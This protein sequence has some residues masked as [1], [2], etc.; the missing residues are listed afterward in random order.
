MKRKPIASAI[1]AAL[2]LLSLSLLSGVAAASESFSISS[3]ASGQNVSIALTPNAELDGQSGNLYVAY[4]DPNTGALYFS[5]GSTWQVYSAGSEPA[6]H[7][8]GTLGRT[9]LSLV[10]LNNPTSFRNF[11]LYAGYGT[12]F[13]DMLARSSYGV[14]FVVP[15]STG[16]SRTLD[17]VE[18]GNTAAPGTDQERASAYSRSTTTVRYRDGSVE[19]RSLAYRNLYHN[20]DEFNGVK[21]GAVYNKNGSVMSD[22]AG[23]VYVS[24]TPDANSLLR[25]ITGTPASVL[26]GNPLYLVTQ[27]EYQWQD[28]VGN[29]LYGKLPMTMK[30][31]NVDQN[32]ATGA[33][34]VT[35]LRNI[36]FSGVNGL[37]IPCA[38]S[39][40]PWNT[41]LGS[42]EYEPDARCQVEPTANSTCS[43]DATMSLAAMTSYG[44]TAPKVYDY[45]LTPEVT[46][47]A[48]GTSTVVKHRVLGRLSREKAEVMPDNKTVY[49]GDDG[50]YNV[51]TMFLADT[52]SDLSAGTLYAAK[53]TQTSSANGGAGTLTW[54]KLGHA[55]DAEL[56]TLAST[57]NFSDIFETAP[58]VE[59]KDSS[60]KVTGYE[61]APA[62][63]TQIIAGHNSGK[64]ENLKLKTGME[65][66]AAFLETRRY[67]A[68]L[69]ATTEWEKY[70]GVTVN[71]KDKKAYHAM[72]RM[73]SGM[74]TSTKDP[75]DHIKLTRNSAGAV[76]EMPMTSAQVDST[77]GA[78][79]SDWVGTSMKAIVVGEDITKDSAGNI[80]HVDKIC[81]P[82]NLAFSEKM[83]VL[84]IGE[85]SSSGHV[86]NFLW[87]YHVDTGVLA[88][89]LSLPAGAESTGLQVHDSLNGFAYIMSNY[90]HAGDFSSNIDSALKSRLTPLID[91]RKAGV[92][93]LG[94]LPKL[95]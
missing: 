22:T 9:A 93:Y 70:E 83:R 44:L 3:S 14:A 66:A 45:G 59:V 80:C 23:N 28:T 76:Y 62:G 78:I 65:K 15:Q 24:E 47:A 58:V 38:G 19:T 95:D 86:N 8:R 10:G 82:D 85:D 68:Y 55:T 30:L 31:A 91:T 79:A 71:V 16:L 75:V 67:A 20:T 61:A 49:Q 63:Y 41:H 54:V 5:D 92:G 43:S 89:V 40:S 53:F 52:A 34:T 51:V 4:S 81:S 72:T 56:A 29:D 46:V 12:S 87:A 26:G 57:L 94:N 42:E 7:Y 60:G 48:D 25:P 64:V 84:F 17:S 21:A 88:R 27:Y 74:E 77:G 13:A 1:R 35:N 36:D 33:L 50:T 6:V 18:F 32:L 11:R 73:R 69:G 2:P 37:W 90:Q 39:L